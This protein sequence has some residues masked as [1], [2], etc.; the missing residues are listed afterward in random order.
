MKLKW[1]GGYFIVAESNGVGDGVGDGV[2]GI[3][4][5]SLGNVSLM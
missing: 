4:R 1:I 5:V 3:E 2:E